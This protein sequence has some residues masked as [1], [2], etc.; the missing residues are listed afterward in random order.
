MIIEGIGIVL[1]AFTAGGTVAGATALNAARIAAAAPRLMRIIQTL[2]TLAASCA[3]PIRFA[4]T[5]LGDLRRELAVFRRVRITIASAFDAERLARVERLRGIVN[6]PRLFNAEDLRGLNP[7]QI[8]KIVDD[9]PVHPSSQGEGIVY[10]DPLRRDRQIRVMEGY[11]NGN[12]PD[13]LTHGPYASIS[14]NGQV[15]KVPLEGNPLL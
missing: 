12:R 1:G 13:P 7:K 3:A 9:W 2:R 5:T 11:L 14:Q 4:A 6:N 10:K 15:I 8:E